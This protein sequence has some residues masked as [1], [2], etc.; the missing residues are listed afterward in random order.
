M[1]FLADGLY[2]KKNPRYFVFV[3]KQFACFCI[4][5][6]QIIHYFVHALGDDIIIR[7]ICVF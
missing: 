3:L 4:L 5:K 1:S 6:R 7:S 2:I